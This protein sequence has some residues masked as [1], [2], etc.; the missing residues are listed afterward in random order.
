MPIP[1]LFFSVTPHYAPKLS[2]G[3]GRWQLKTAYVANLKIL[4]TYALC[5][6]F[7]N[8]LYITSLIDIFLIDLLKFFML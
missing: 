4:V 6:F 5:F 2:K 1:Y 8:F 3:S 7:G